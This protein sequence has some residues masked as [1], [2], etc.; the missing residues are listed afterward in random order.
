MWAP[1]NLFVN[2]LIE[3]FDIVSFLPGDRN[4]ILVNT[5]GILA[6]FGFGDQCFAADEVV[7]ACGEANDVIDVVSTHGDGFC[8]LFDAEPAVLGFK[9]AVLGSLLLIPLCSGGVD[10]VWYGGREFFDLLD[11][12]GFHGCFPHMSS[13]MAAW[14]RSVMDMSST[15][16]Q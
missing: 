16:H 13:L 15:F 11:F 8:G 4:L 6:A 10:D 5:C 14:I 12:F 9:H 7:E 3:V 1:V 2:S